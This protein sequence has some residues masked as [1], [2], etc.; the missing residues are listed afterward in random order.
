MDEELVHTIQSDRYGEVEDSK[1]YSCLVAGLSTE[2]QSIVDYNAYGSAYRLWHYIIETCT[3][4]AK[5]KINESEVQLIQLSKKGD[6]DLSAYVGRARA[7]ATSIRKLGGQYCNIRL[8]VD[9]LSG[10][11][12][13]HGSV[14]S[15][16]EWMIGDEDSDVDK[17]E[18]A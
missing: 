9:I 12:D 14:I 18:A 13:E 1:A 3:K 17:L 11:R 10:L 15:E 4:G 7:L 6:E 5:W 2:S 16:L 8:C